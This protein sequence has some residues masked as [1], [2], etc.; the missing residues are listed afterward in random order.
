MWITFYIN[1]GFLFNLSSIFY[2]NEEYYLT[3]FSWFISINYYLP[4]FKTNNNFLLNLNKSCID[5]FKKPV[6]Y[7]VDSPKIIVLIPTSDCI[8]INVCPSLI[9]LK[10]ILSQTPKIFC[11]L[12][13]YNNH[14]FFT[15]FFTFPTYFINSRSFFL[16]FDTTQ[17]FFSWKYYIA[18]TFTFPSTN[19]ISG[20]NLD[21]RS[22]IFPII[23]FSFFIKS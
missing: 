15:L 22:N 19:I 2:D 12:Y 18:W 13:F 1:T 5:L 8:N 3:I 11:G 4:L 16:I 23:I 21:I 17:I 20:D 6:S 10:Y 14:N 9:V 7:Y